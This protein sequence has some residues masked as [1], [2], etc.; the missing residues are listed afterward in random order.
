MSVNKFYWNTGMLICYTSS[1][2]AFMLPEHSW[3]AAKK[4]VPQSLKYILPGPLLKRFANPSF[5]RTLAPRACFTWN[6]LHQQPPLPS[7][8]TSVSC[9]K[10]VFTQQTL[11]PM[12]S[13]SLKK[14]PSKSSLLWWKHNNLAQIRHPEETQPQNGYWLCSPLGSS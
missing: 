4:T 12:H 9:R 3:V 13:H 14:T 6:S 11:T 5:R 8:V 2:D 1:M 10:L 7:V